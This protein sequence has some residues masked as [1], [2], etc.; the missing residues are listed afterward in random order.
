M[1]DTSFT[2]FSFHLYILVCRSFAKGL[3]VVKE[4][5]ATFRT[6]EETGRLISY[7]LNF[8]AFPIII[9]ELGLEIHSAVGKLQR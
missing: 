5:G 9:S 6:V 3:Q 4:S 1:R 2:F 8:K 7:I